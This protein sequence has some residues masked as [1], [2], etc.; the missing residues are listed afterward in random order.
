ME[1]TLLLC[2]LAVG[3]IACTWVAGPAGLPG[4]VPADR[5]RGRG[6]VRPDG[7][8][9]R[10]LRGRRA[11][12]A[13]A[14]PAV[15]RGAGH[16]AGRLQGQPAA[17]PAAV[18]RAGGVHDVRGR[19]GGAP[20][21][22]R[23]L[24]G[25]RPRDRC[26]RRAA[27]RRGRDRDRPPDRA[28]AADR[29]D[30]RGRVAA[31]RRDRAG[32]AR[33]RARGRRGQRVRAGRRRPGLPAGGRRRRGGRVPLLPRRREAPPA[34]D[35]PGA[36]QRPLAGGPVRGVRRRRAGARVGRDRRRRGRPAAGSQGADPP[37]RAVAD[38]R[39]AEL[40]DDRVRPREHRLPAHRPPGPLDRR[41]RRR[42]RP[43]VGPDHRRSARPR[44]PP[45]SCS[46]CCG[47]SRR[48]TSS[49]GPAPTR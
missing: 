13:A 6:V 30:P 33:H 26:R 35:R 3:V 41:G 27:G 16:L 12:R 15:R 17:D 36:R 32:R 8:R 11:V 43:V 48:A 9:R 47:C 29:D 42:G 34:P 44:W 2:G 1:I 46:G 4:A 40:A 25:D 39:A 19:A 22:A 28:A 14:A 49:S 37:D 7:A 5:R 21:A 23:R 20:A 45:A 18:G 38:R 31:Q 10:A 24:V